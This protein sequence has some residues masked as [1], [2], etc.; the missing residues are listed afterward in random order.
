MTT[1]RMC[2]TGVP[3]VFAPDDHLC[4]KLRYWR[5]DGGIQTSIPASFHDLTIAEA[6]HWARDYE[7]AN[8]DAQVASATERWV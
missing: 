4:C 1:P 8:P 3:H 7:R 6:Q 2:P 5:E